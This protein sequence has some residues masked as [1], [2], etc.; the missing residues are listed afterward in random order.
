MLA[1]LDKIP[2]GTPRLRRWAFWLLAAFLGYV[3]FGFLAVPPILKSVLTTQLAE[4]LK[5]PA[6]IEKVYFNPLL[7]HLEI[8][9]LGVEKL[10][11]GGDLLSA[12]KIVAA[13]SVSSLWQFAPVVSYLK[14]EDLT[15]DVTF[16]GN[17]RYSI[18][19]ILDSGAGE[20]GPERE[21]AVFPFALYDFELSNATLIF[22]DRSHD[23][24]HVISD[25]S[26]RVPF[27]SSIED[28][29]KEYTQPTLSAVVNGD[30]V[31]LEGKTLPFDQTLLTEFRLG[32][33]NVDLDQYWR[34]LPVDTPLTLKSG[35]FTSDI[36]LFFERPD[37]HSVNLFLG[38]GGR[39]TDLDLEDPREGSVVRLDE[40]AFEIERFSLRDNF[41]ALKKVVLTKP[42]FKIIRNPGDAVNWAGYFPAD[43]KE[44]EAG[45]EPENDAEA[46]GSPFRVDV[47]LVEIADGAVEWIDRAVA[48]G[49][50]RTFSGLEFSGSELASR[51]G[52]PGS[53]EAAIGTAER[54]TAKGTATVEPLDANFTVT[55]E[56]LSLP[57]FAAYLDEVQPLA[58]DS[59]VL[60][61]SAG[62]TVTMA[63]GRAEVRVA[64]G[65]AALTDLAARK[66]DAE[67][68]SLTLGRLAVS[69]ASLDPAEKAVSVGEIALTAPAATVVR[70]AD[71]TIDLQALFAPEGDAAAGQAEPEPDENDPAPGWSARVD[72]LT[73]A[74]GGFT[75]RDQTLRQPAELGVR[76]F[77]LDLE[78]L[79]TEP[80]AS[81]PYT[82]EG[83]WTGGG[84]FSARGTATLDPLTANGRLQ[85]ADIGLRPL[86]AYLAETTELLFARG[87]AYAN[88]A[89][90]FTQGDPPELTARGDAALAGLAVKTTFGD[91]E[92]VGLD[93]LDVKS[94][95]F[96]S[97]PNRL[98]VG[99]IILDGPR[100]LVEYAEDGRLNVRRALR[101]PQPEPVDSEQDENSEAETTGETDAGQAGHD[102]DQ[103]GETE[104]EPPLFARLEIGK[105]SMK[106]GALSFRDASVHPVFTNEVTKMTLSLTDIG[107]TRE[108]RPKVDFSA[109]IGPTPMS[110]TGV[111]NPL[112]TPI[113]SDLAVSVN[114]MELVPLSPYTL[115][116]LAYPVEK[117]RL[118]ADVTFK[119]E[120]WKLDAQNKFFIEQ[121]VLGP[122]DKRP[123]APNVPVKFGLALLQD[124]NGDLE[125][126]LPI[127][128]RL[129]DPSFR[130]GGIVFRAIV[131][132]LFK[133][134]ASPFSLIGS[135]FGGGGE[136]MDFIVFEPGRARIDQNG[137]SKLATVIKALTE[138]DRLKLEV[139]GVVDPVADANG[140]TRVIFDRKIKEQKYLDQPRSVRAETTVDTMEVAPG[141]YE[142]YLFEA[143]AEEPDEEGVR[144]T[145]LFMVDRQPVEVM[146]KFILDRIV[147]TDELLHELAM[148]RANAVKTHI[149]ETNPELAD[150]VFLL[151][152]EDAEG[153]T[154]VPAHRAD[155][156]IN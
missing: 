65:A 100:A 72:H 129:D 93:R 63:D 71:G 131:N 106:N 154:G 77:A 98:S 138:R 83:V 61:A 43:G 155:L 108:A 91:A 84:T 2:F 79:S 132:L 62:I 12:G 57:D 47:H 119:T 103:G 39:L 107:Q 130:I 126:N 37:T 117:G 105:V 52:T 115:K 82:A 152:R 58:V 140:L 81:V 145:T 94:I 60:G 33:V 78:N 67:K 11:G 19:D 54:F 38:G 128:G 66:P 45:A 74:D 116:N 125:L 118:Y 104:S 114:G 143:Y 50:S 51:G 5:R 41:L 75:L 26:M 17:G 23:K 141:E 34:Y 144:P 8:T 21:G 40:L 86:D 30:P 149:I 90:G 121:L 111:L 36:S 35:R 27:T 87:R 6:R 16:H 80:G 92:F 101:L 59:G 88:L 112:I 4:N 76:Q 24:R 1:F 49:F 7:L 134:L 137:E 53:F 124:G 146:E 142:E 148:R 15:V 20:S 109:E 46:E 55:A 99:E 28:E 10:E 127:S 3:L 14:L 73:V 135:I 44:A 48:G 56:N 156:G 122:K 147:I 42:Y 31:E 97:A 110:V 113:Y 69:G 139:D 29:Q 120:D 96:R 13:P 22:D 136:N 32:A 151:D 102:A 133:A 85:L 18:S 89:Y 68:P 9:G 153:K 25:L 95:D 70:Q 64:D 150:R 123:D